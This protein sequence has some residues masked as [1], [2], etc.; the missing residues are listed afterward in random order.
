MSFHDVLIHFSS[1][2]T[3][4]LYRRDRDPWSC[5]W[6]LQTLWYY[7]KYTAT[8]ARWLFA[9][10]HLICYLLLVNFNTAYLASAFY[11]Y[12]ALRQITLFKTNTVGIQK[13][14]HCK[15]FVAHVHID[16]GENRL[17]SVHYN[18]YSL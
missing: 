17:G 16:K 2:G 9:C 3:E 7:L 10:H 13:I 1:P 6:N 4:E 18:Q 5:G 15:Q 11:L 12:F 14:I 8:Q